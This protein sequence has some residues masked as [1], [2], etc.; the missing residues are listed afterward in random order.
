LQIKADLHKKFRQRAALDLAERSLP[1][2][3]AYTAIWCVI[4]FATGYHRQ[5][6]MLAYGA[7]G[8]FVF[9]GILRFIYQLTHRRLIG[10]HAILNYFFLGVCVFL[11]AMMWSGLFA[12]F[13]VAATDSEMRLLVVIATI[14]LCSGGSTS[15]APVRQLSAAYAGVI[16]LPTCIGI[17][18]YNPQAHVFLYLLIIYIGFTL[19]LMQRGHREYWTA[20][21]NEAALEDKTRQLEILSET[22]ALTGVFNRRYFDRMLEKEWHRCSRDGNTLSLLILD[23]DHF[24]RIND[25]YG[26]LAGDEYLRQVAAGLKSCFQR[27]SDV[28]ARYGGE[29]FAILAPGTPEADVARLAERLRQEVQDR[30]VSYA[31]RPLRTTVSIGIAGGQPDYRQT[32]ENLVRRADEALYRAKNAGRNRVDINSPPPLRRLA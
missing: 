31:G 18:M 3:L 28:I 9:C 26:H 19:L 23:I 8:G 2:M 22:D 27:C 21:A 10:A 32:S 6:P 25:T 20:L 15:Y 30:V 4:A 16:T 13:F 24:K 5:Q 29:E 11:P 17:V 7:L 1:G 12:Y 14:G